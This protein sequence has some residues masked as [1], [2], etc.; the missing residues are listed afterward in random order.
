MNGPAL[1]FFLRAGD[2][3]RAAGLRA[4][5]AARFG[6]GERAARRYHLATFAAA[7]VQLCAVK[8]RDRSSVAKGACTCCKS[9]SAR[10][11]RGRISLVFAVLFC[12]AC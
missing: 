5:L 7:A 4:G 2:L 3:A 11:A 6:A 12:F 8:I 9:R 10:C 1:A